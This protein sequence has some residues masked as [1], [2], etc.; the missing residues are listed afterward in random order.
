[1]NTETCTYWSSYSPEFT[2]CDLCLWGCLKNHVYS[3]NWTMTT[4]LVQY[5]CDYASVCQLFSTVLFCSCKWWIFRKYRFLV[6]TTNMFFYRLTQFNATFIQLPLLIFKLC[7]KIYFFPK[8]DPANNA[9]L[10][11]TFLFIFQV[12]PSFKSHPVLSICTEQ[13]KKITDELQHN[14]P[15]PKMPAF[16]AVNK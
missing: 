5:I 7:F 15:A 8:H 10:Q 6:L 9:F 4:E 3:Q 1:M 14:L 13:C 2:R 12:D 16:S 11:N